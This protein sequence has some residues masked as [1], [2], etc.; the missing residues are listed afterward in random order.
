MNTARTRQTERVLVTGASAGIGAALAR[1]FAR[2]G[3]DLVMVAR[4]VDKLDALAR[5]LTK[6]HGVR[7]TVIAADLAQEGEVGK[8]AA[9]LKRRRLAIDILVNNAGV[10]HQG[11]FHKMAPTAHEEIIRVNI[12]AATAML[13]HFVPPMV[14]RG[15]GR[16]LNV[17]STSSFLPVPFMAT[18]AAS[19]AY[20]LSLTESMSE[21]LQGTGVSL[22]ALCPGVTATPMMDTIAATNPQFVRLIGATVL[23]VDEVAEAGY[24]ACMRGQVIRVPG[25]VNVLMTVAGRALPKWVTRSVLGIVGRR[26]N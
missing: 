25:G 16:V 21:E 7:T 4:S 8:L 9:K 18:Y 13:G 2:A 14:Q 19:K 1:R 3:H 10:N 11:S 20:L 5:E 24:D 26:S 22:S 23:N 12:A 17:G 6:S 15:H